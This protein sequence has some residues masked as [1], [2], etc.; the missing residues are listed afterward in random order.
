M[1]SFYG[2][3]T[4]GRITIDPPST[5]VSA[6]TAQVFVRAIHVPRNIKRFRFRLDTSKPIEVSLV[7]ARD[8]GLL[9]GWV[10]TE[11][12]TEGYFSASGSQ[13]LE[14]GSSGLLFRIVVSG[15][16]EPRIDVPL[17]FDNSI[18][19]AGKA[20]THPGAILLGQ[21]IP[22]SGRIAFRSTRDG[23]SDIFVMRFD[24]TG[25][26]NLTR[27]SLDD[28]FLGTWSPDG[29]QIAFDSD[30]S[31]L[32][33]VRVRAIHVMDD[34][35]QNVRTLTSN[36]SPNSLPAW[37]PDGLKIAFDSNRDGNREIYAMDADGSNQ[38]RLTDSPGD[39]WWPSWSPDSSKIVFTS[40]RDGDAEVYV[41][42][43]DG[44]DPLNLTNDPSGDFRP[45]WSPD[46]R[47]IAFYSV[48]DGNR[49]VYVMEPDGTG[50]RNLTNNPD[51]D[52]YPA[53][54]PA[55]DRIAFTSL[56]DGNSE[57]YTM[58][59][60]NGG[61]QANLTNHPGDDSAPSWGP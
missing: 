50:Q 8:G 6:S 27:T 43:A 7:P 55:G 12:D 40:T 41:M 20:L 4:Q 13:P 52:W 46:G 49:E 33:G 61:S 54:S 28:E 38:L 48:R 35:G 26:Q 29:G 58:F 39:D 34:D 31:R 16:T 44:T 45:V 30:R 57:I 37:S 17:T 56:R 15:F 53:W 22:P 14:L 1:G 9:E 19:P 18:Y 3:D 51:D 10:L 47:N 21:R 32:S 24:G 2:L 42:N 23:R 36:T 60:D 59:A 5:N 25:Q 11:P